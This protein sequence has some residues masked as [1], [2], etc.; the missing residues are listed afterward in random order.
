M[1]ILSITGEK[2]MKQVKFA[3]WQHWFKI[4]P[5]KYP[6]PRQQKLY[7][8]ITITLCC[9]MSQHISYTENAKGKSEAFQGCRRTTE[10]QNYYY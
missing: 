3:P 9:A 5:S 8:L 2:T 1:R 7:L 4:F 6:K 10:S